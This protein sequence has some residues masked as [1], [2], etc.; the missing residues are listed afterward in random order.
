MQEGNDAFKKGKYEIA[1]EMYS[2]A[3]SVDEDNVQ[4]AMS[5]RITSESYFLC[6]LERF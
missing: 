5:T 1:V 2:E 6:L 3:L 4:S